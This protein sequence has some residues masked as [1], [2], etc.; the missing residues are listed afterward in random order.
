MKRLIVISAFLYSVTPLAYAD[1][2]LPGEE[3]IPIDTYNGKGSLNGED[4]SFSARLENTRGREIVCA[5]FAEGRAT[6]DGTTTTVDVTKFVK[7]QYIEVDQENRVNFTFRNANFGQGFKLSR[8]SI[9][10]R[11]SC[12]DMERDNGTGGIGN[13]DPRSPGQNGRHCDNTCRADKTDPTQCGR[14][15]SGDTDIF[16]D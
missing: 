8:K 12:Q 13:C 7:G 16:A 11:A 6:K 9:K 4:F 1:R 5:L 14:T 10:A 3:Y 2:R 15:P